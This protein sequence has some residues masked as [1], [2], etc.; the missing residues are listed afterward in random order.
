MAPLTSDP[1]ELVEAG[2]SRGG[3]AGRVAGGHRTIVVAVGPL[4]V[5]V[6]GRALSDRATELVDAD[7]LAVQGRG[8]VAGG[9]KVAARVGEPAGADIGKGNRI[10]VDHD[11]IGGDAV[12][13]HRVNATRDR[14][15]GTVVIEVLEREQL[16]GVGVDQ[17][18]PLSE[19]VDNGSADSPDE[20]MGVGGAPLGP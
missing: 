2:A 11:A 7:V 15:S 10:V 13:G 4:E 20:P 16:T 18:L 12:G 1:I 17:S 8:D 9:A 3:V 19:V 5:D 14:A 6:A